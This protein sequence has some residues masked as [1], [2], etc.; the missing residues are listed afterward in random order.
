MPLEAKAKS[1]RDAGATKTVLQRKDSQEVENIPGW[2]AL[3]RRG[4]GGQGAGSPKVLLFEFNCG[5]YAW[6]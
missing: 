5:G 6:E 3:L 4:Y 1:R 2:Q